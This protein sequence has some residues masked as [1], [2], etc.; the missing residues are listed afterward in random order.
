MSY[1]IVFIRLIH[2]TGSYIFKSGHLTIKAYHYTEAVHV[3]DL[4]CLE[5]ATVYIYAGVNL[6]KNRK[7]RNESI[8]TFID[9]SIKKLH[10]QLQ[11]TSEELAFVH[12]H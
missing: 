9:F 11:A 4:I 7:T 3:I 1:S 6:T 2:L 10:Y 8:A 5:M 12:K